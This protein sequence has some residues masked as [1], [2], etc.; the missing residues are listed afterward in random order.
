MDLQSKVERQFYRP[1]ESWSSFK[2]VAEQLCQ[3][4]VHVNG[5]VYSA[6]GSLAS[7]LALLEGTERGGR[8]RFAVKKDKLSCVVYNRLSV[9]S[10][11]ET[12]PSVIL[13]M[14]SRRHLVYMASC[15]PR[16]VFEHVRSAIY[17]L[18]QPELCKVFLRTKEVQ[19][20]LNQ[21]AERHSELAL[22]VREYTARSLIADPGSRKRVRTV[23]EWTDEEHGTVF[24]K[25]AD[26]KQWLAGLR[27][28][29]RGRGE[30][31]GRIWRDVTFSCESGFGLFFN[32]I[33]VT[34]GNSV[35]DSR[36][37][38]DSRG[39]LSNPEHASRPVR[40][41]YSED[42]FA[43]KKQNIRLLQTLKTLNDSA[44]SVYHPNPYLHASLVDYVDGSSY[45][46]WVTKPGS[47]LVVPKRKATADSMERVCN[48]IC[49]EFQEG[50]IQELA[51]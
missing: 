28:E 16:E 12:K 39:R 33:V 35:A 14:D 6:T 5:A 23:R 19:R 44:L 20:A 40:I 17:R 29:V 48:F 1:Y 26:E 22:R 41:S 10:G 31:A 13:W 7:V 27:L 24:Q 2:S 15:Q 36:K 4:G 46:V 9:F 42:V 32:S 45:E 25:L 30:A 38:F 49:D 47:I 34:L 21:L 3:R 43:N 8:K 51:S 11:V 18:L 50:D 37:F